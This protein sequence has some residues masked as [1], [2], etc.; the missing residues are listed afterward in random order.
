M[1]FLITGGT[2]FIGRRLVQRL[3]EGGHQITV[4]SRR[5][6]K[7]VRQL[8]SSEVKPVRSATAVN[9]SVYYDA[10]INLAG[11]GIMDARWTP[12]RK[13]MLLDSRVGI[14]LELADLIERMDRKPGRFIS[15][16][17]IGYYG[18]HEPED[19]QDESSPAGTDFAASLCVRWE[20]AAG[21][22]S[23]MGI[24]TSIVRTGIVLHPDGGALQKM[25]LPFRLA[26]G[27]PIGDG[28]QMMSWIH[29]DDMIELLVFLINTPEA[30]GQFNATAPE[31]V[32]NKAF[33]RA[34]GKALTR[35][36]LLPVPSLMMKLMLGES[37]SLLLQGQDV[38][39]V[40]L[41]DLGFAF[42]YPGIDKA[43]K[44][45]LK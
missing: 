40:H 36:A 29:M 10:I 28:K 19:R 43:L 7:D 5:H 26:L 44:H 35:P 33:A 41:M 12:A 23:A 21:R 14:T 45:L 27:G 34:L 24:P 2:G 25:L 42:R 37:S 18:A 8:L 32:S 11:E 38:R 31:P 16:S 22:I 4:I 13:R 3:L 20:Q 17:A 30:E 9:P 6:A 39:P 1:Q 15:S